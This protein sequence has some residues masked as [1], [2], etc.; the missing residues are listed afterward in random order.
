MRCKERLASASQQRTSRRSRRGCAPD[1]SSDTAP[2]PPVCAARSLADEMLRAL[3]TA[4]VRRTP[5][6]IAISGTAGF[7][8]AVPATEGAHRRE[9]PT[10]TVR[11]RPAALL[12][13][14]AE[15]LRACVLALGKVAPARMRCAQTAVRHGPRSPR[16]RFCAYA[17]RRPWRAS[18]RDVR[19]VMH[20]TCV[21]FGITLTVHHP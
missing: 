18:V 11:S 14:L 1:G 20:G 13:A 2:L 15:S 21:R 9:A 4:P 12:I 10:C 6:S 5:P 17:C 19:T 3:A 16:R 8:A 7:D